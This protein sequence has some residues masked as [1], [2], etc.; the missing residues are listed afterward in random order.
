MVGGRVH[1]SPREVSPLPTSSHSDRVNPPFIAGLRA[2]P[3]VPFD[4]RSNGIK[5][6]IIAILTLASVMCTAS[7][8]RAQTRW[9]A[10][11]IHGISNAALA[12]D[13]KT[14]T[15]VVASFGTV[16]TC[17]DGGK[18][19]R[20]QPYNFNPWY[21]TIHLVSKDSFLVTASFLVTS[22]VYGV[23]ATTN[24]G[25]TFRPKCDGLPRREARLPSLTGNPR[26]SSEV[27]L[28]NDDIYRTTDFGDSWSLHTAG[29]ANGMA[30]YPLGISPVDSDFMCVVN[31]FKPE[32]FITFDG[33]KSWP[34]S[35]ILAPFGGQVYKIVITPKGNIYAGEWMSADSGVS[36]K[37]ITALVSDNHE[38][39]SL[40]LIGDC[41]FNP[42]DGMVSISHGYD[43]GVFQARDGDTLFTSTPLSSARA[44][45]RRGADLAI[46]PVS[47]TLFAAIMDS[48][49]KYNS[50]VYECISN[51]LFT[52]PVP[53]IRANPLDDN[54]MLAGNNYYFL[55]S[56]D[57][58]KT[59]NVLAN[60]WG[61][62]NGHF[63]QYSPTVPGLVVMGAEGGA[64]LGFM[65][66][67]GDSVRG[68][69]VKEPIWGQARFDPFNGHDLYLG[70]SG[71]LLRL[72]DSLLLGNPNWE[73]APEKVNSDHLI[74]RF[75]F[76]PNNEGILYAIT[77]DNRIVRYRDRGKTSEV[78]FDSLP[79]DDPY[80]TSIALSKGDPAH[81]YVG[82]TFGCY[83]S[84]DTG[85][86]WT[87][88]TEGMASTFVHALRADTDHPGVVYAGMWNDCEYEPGEDV[89]CK[90]GVNMT[91]DHGLTWHPIIDS[92][93]FNW[94]I[95]DIEFLH[96]PRRLVVGTQCGAYE[97]AL[98]D[99][100]AVQPRPPSGVALFTLGQN[101]PNPC[102]GT[103]GDGTVIPFHLGTYSHVQLRVYDALGR[104][105]ATLV[106][107]YLQAGF[108]QRSL[109]TLEAGNLQSGVYAYELVV[110]GEKAVRRMIVQ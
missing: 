106:D 14:N 91:T 18:T 70:G 6:S 24:G 3:F 77:D 52:V 2:P 53:S 1:C 103:S 35:R 58:G 64:Y 21:P 15:I 9:N 105:A 11:G 96:E 51:G 100:S 82:A 73:I 30:L 94:N 61:S 59:W 25:R 32:F 33:G 43:G 89:D 27:F 80:L 41:V 38:Y 46:D 87:L 65:F 81:V 29:R 40:S 62:A 23:L 83:V 88:R 34:R 101:Y 98:P 19:W 71:N 67:S 28:C 92:G 50:D 68:I 44:Y 79:S 85:R 8:T 84:S 110:N 20:H 109:S 74:H 16:A 54:I 31:S 4:K 102:G 66:D 93:L 76:D 56:I 69:F 5:F 108:H 39:I 48:L 95:M 22:H 10:L 63:V 7:Q 47:G 104:T 45:T 12:F 107:G 60:G 42:H 99:I 17:T 49:Y 90:G 26:N 97:L 86:T 72:N 55:K 75:E 78:L 36:W 13:V 37:R 57:G